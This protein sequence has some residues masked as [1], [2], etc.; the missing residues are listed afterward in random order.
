MTDAHTIRAGTAADIPSV[1][2]LWRAAESRPSATDTDRALEFLLVRDPESLLIAEAEGTIVGSVIVGW[3]G[4]R[5]SFYRLAVHPQWQRRGLAT[6]LIHAG[7]ER[8]QG[9]GAIRLTAIVASEQQGAMGLWEAL[10]YERQADTSRFI[11]VL[12]S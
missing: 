9:L 1:L 7:E 12:A 3:D 2:A 5:G 11:R 8:L 6:G 10:G 4:W